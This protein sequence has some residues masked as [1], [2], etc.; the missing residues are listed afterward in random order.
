[1][2]II[3][4]VAGGERDPVAPGGGLGDKDGRANDGAHAVEAGR[5]AGEDI[6]SIG[7]GHGPL[8]VRLK[9]AVI[10]GVEEDIAIGNAF[11][12]GIALAIVV[13]VEEDI[14]PNGGGAHAEI[15]RCQRRDGANADDLLVI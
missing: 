8:L 2:M 1:M 13:G 5:Q 7:I 4:I 6:V 15:D 10:V 3:G 14:A 9:D 11:F 12:A